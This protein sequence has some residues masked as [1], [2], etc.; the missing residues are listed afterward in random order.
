MYRF[1]RIIIKTVL[2]IL[3]R[4]F[5]SA[6]VLDSEIINEIA[7]WPEGFTMMFMVK[8]AGPFLTLKKFKG[9]IRYCGLKK[10]AEADLTVFFKN[11]ASAFML[12]TI[13][14]GFPEGYARHII[15]VGG[16][17]PEAMRLIR[18]FNIVQAYL[19]P[20]LISKRI[21]KRVPRMGFRRQ[22]NRILIYTAGIPTGLIR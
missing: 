8:P 1:K 22:F 20:G 10:P 13:Q 4:A 11:T 16:D 19:F 21:L 6:S 17:I 18:C 7:V 14:I 2:F 5:Q 3:G 9:K 12:F 15:S